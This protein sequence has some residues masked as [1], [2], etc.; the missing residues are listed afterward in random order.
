MGNHRPP[1]APTHGTVPGTLRRHEAR[2]GALLRPGHP[3]EWAHGLCGRASLGP[4]GGAASGQGPPFAWPPSPVRR[5]PP[6]SRC[7]EVGGLAGACPRHSPRAKRPALPTQPA[8]LL[9]Q[10]LHV[11]FQ[12]Q[13]FVK[14]LRHPQNRDINCGSRTTEC[15][16]SSSPFGKSALN[17][18]T[19]IRSPTMKGGGGGT[20]IIWHN[21]IGAE[22]QQLTKTW[23]AQAT[24]DRCTKKAIVIENCLGVNT[25]WLSDNLEKDEVGEIGE[26]GAPPS[27]SSIQAQGWT[28]GERCDICE[29]FYLPVLPAALWCPPKNTWCRLPLNSFATCWSPSTS[30][31]QS[32]SLGRECI[33]PHP[34][35]VGCSPLGGGGGSCQTNVQSQQPTQGFVFCGGREG[36]GGGAGGH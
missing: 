7:T 25:L 29:P 9:E 13:K 16:N 18:C 30:T 3:F 8:H 4:L 14:S 23:S 36:G 20:C 1:G 33:V 26:G 2:L 22:G 19:K 24:I 32:S 27:Q 12:C 21:I 5:A 28:R 10:A 35:A 15:T 17:D 34:S 6:C 31:T 11:H